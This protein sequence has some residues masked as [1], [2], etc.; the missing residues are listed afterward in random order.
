MQARYP[1]SNGFNVNTPEFRM[2]NSS[3]SPW[4]GRCPPHNST[5]SDGFEGDEAKPIGKTMPIRQYFRRHHTFHN[6]E[7]RIGELTIVAERP[8]ED[9]NLAALRP[10]KKPKSCR[11]ERQLPVKQDEALV[12]EALPRDIRAEATSIE[13]H[14]HSE[15]TSSHFNKDHRRMANDMASKGSPM[16]TGGAVSSSSEHSSQLKQRSIYH[17]DMVKQDI[18]GEVRKP[19]HKLRK[20]NELLIAQEMMSVKISRLPPASDSDS[21]DG[22]S[23]EWSNQENESDKESEADDFKMNFQYSGDNDDDIEQAEHTVVV[24]K[25]QPFPN[26]QDDCDQAEY[27][28]RPRR[29]KTSNLPLEVDEEILDGPNPTLIYPEGQKEIRQFDE[30]S[31]GTRS[32]CLPVIQSRGSSPVAAVHFPSS[33]DSQGSIEL[34]DS[35]ILAAVQTSLPSSIPET[36][37]EDQQ[38]TLEEHSSQQF[39]APQASYFDFASQQLGLFRNLNPE[40]MRSMPT[41]KYMRQNEQKP[42][43]MAAGGIAYSESFRDNL[44]SPS[45][46][47]N[48]SEPVGLDT[49]YQKISL[50]VL[51]RRASISLGSIP[52]TSKRRE[53]SLHFVPPFK[54]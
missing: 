40:R 32:R 35:Q 8:V 26:T 21:Q 42:L 30:R 49:S 1:R 24:M 4:P 52:C 25:P 54:R 39:L 29:P 2:P 53:V 19:F 18:L 5:H 13:N 43:L 15:S 16:L 22:N 37:V 28:W 41:T 45:K 33:R 17:D 27:S 48:S 50:A 44:V 11:K 36:Q 3:K 31:S 47:R 23:E 38:M 14:G 34:G 9:A 7:L 51:T 46:S 20:N 6:I 12:I 10:L